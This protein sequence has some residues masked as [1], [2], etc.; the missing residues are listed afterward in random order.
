MRTIRSGGLE[1]VILV[2]L[3]LALVPGQRVRLGGLVG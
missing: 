3:V 1:K 2:T